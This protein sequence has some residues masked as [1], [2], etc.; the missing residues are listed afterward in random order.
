MGNHGLPPHVADCWRLRAT[1]AAATLSRASIL[2]HVVSLLLGGQNVD[3]YIIVKWEGALA[4]QSLRHHC[5][6]AYLVA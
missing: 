5:G 1:D 6:I 3:I 2:S 4:K